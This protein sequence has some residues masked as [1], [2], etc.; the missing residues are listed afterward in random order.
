MHISKYYMTPI[1]MYAPCFYISIKL[2]CK[3]KKVQTPVTGNPNIMNG[4]CL[5]ICH[6]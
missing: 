5:N 4:P 3:M 1:S 6:Y 2:N